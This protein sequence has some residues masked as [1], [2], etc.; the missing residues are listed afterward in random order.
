MSWIA[1]VPTRPDSTMA[2]FFQAVEIA[3]GEV[4]GFARIALATMASGPATRAFW[5]CSL[6]AEPGGS[7]ARAACTKI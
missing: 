4:C 7:L 3:Y 1:V 6:G 5:A 2:P